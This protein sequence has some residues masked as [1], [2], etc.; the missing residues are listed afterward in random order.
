MT[1]NNSAKTTFLASQGIW[2]GAGA[3]IDVSGQAVYLPSPADPNRLVGSVLDGSV[4]INAQR[5]YLFADPDS[6]LDASGTQAPLD[7]PNAFGLYQREYLGSNGGVI[8]LTAAEG[9]HLDGALL[10]RS[11][12]LPGNAGGSLSVAID[13]TQR[14][15]DQTNGYLVGDRTVRVTTDS[16]GG[17]PCDRQQE[18]PALPGSPPLRARSAP[19]RCMPSAAVKAMTP[20]LDPR[21]SR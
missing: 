14:R 4:R 7:I 15:G 8:A 20:P 17:G 18:P 19:S 5:G 2:L 13:A 10:A 12:G 1:L 11:G 9:M 21:Y 16:G 3:R 6:V